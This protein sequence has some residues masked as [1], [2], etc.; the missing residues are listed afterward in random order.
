MFQ[1]AVAHELFSDRETPWVGMPRPSFKALSRMSSSPTR[2]AGSGQL[3]RPRRFKALS[4]M[5]S[6]PT[7][8][9]HLGGSRERRPFQSAVAHELFSDM[10]ET[11][12]IHILRLLFQSA[13]AH[14]LFSDQ[15][16][17]RQLPQYKGVS[18]RCRA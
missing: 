11:I 8:P 18:K 1:S 3:V 2:G 12:K 6:S 14:E 10:V 9:P 5:S 17:V 16:L 4:R 7:V 13:V 15:S